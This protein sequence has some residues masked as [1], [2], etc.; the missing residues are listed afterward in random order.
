MDLD[1]RAKEYLAQIENEVTDFLVNLMSIRSY[2][3]EELEACEYCYQK[4]NEIKGV[5]VEK[6]MI[7]NS[8]KNHPLHCASWLE[9]L[10]YTGHYNIEVVWPGTG[11]EKPLYMNAHIDTV[12]AFAE[13]LLPPQVKDGIVYG[14]GACDDKGSIASIYTV[15]RLLEKFQIKTPFDVIGHIVVEEEIGGNG[16][17]AITDRP[18]EGQAAVNLEPSTGAI[19]P[20]ARGAMMLQLKATAKSKKMTPGAAM[21]DNAFFLVKKAAEVILEEHKKYCEECLAVPTKYYEGYRPASAFGMVHGG[22]APDMLPGTA[23]GR[24]TITFVPNITAAELKGRMNAALGAVP[25]L[26][27]TVDVEYIFERDNAVEEFDHPFVLEFQKCAKAN[28]FRADLE[29]MLSCCDKYFYQNVH[30]I[31]TV[32]FGPGR[33]MDAH[34]LSEQVPMKEVLNCG[35]TIFDWVI[36]KS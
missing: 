12:A 14:I 36:S 17:L 27:D 8:I 18:M 22:N 30:D 28:G 29:A 20:A 19:F 7:D 15:F 1:K 35:K 33:L 32:V 25:E 34:N 26:R 2:P 9:H 21:T 24:V 5:K 3:N 4:F 23:I 6:M 13:S 11:E 16:A 31:P 10:D